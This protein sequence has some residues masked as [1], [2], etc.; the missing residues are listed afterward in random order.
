MSV[1]E[2]KESLRNYIVLNHATK[3]IRSRNV[4]DDISIGFAEGCVHG[5]FGR[6][7]SGKTM[8]LRAISGLIRLSSGSIEVEGINITERRCFPLTDKNMGMFPVSH[9]LKQLIYDDEDK[10]SEK[11]GYEKWSELSKY[12]YIV[13]SED[14]YNDILT[15]AEALTSRFADLE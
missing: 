7:G 8:I 11:M 3:T 10:D 14:N 1:S 5:L 9:E 4:L 15:A 12:D 13:K 6:N 2:K